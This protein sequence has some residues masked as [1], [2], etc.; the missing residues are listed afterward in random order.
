MQY[1]NLNIAQK[2]MKM[3][4]NNDFYNTFILGW[5]YLRCVIMPC[6]ADCRKRFAWETERGEVI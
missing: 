4:N 2:N 6:R 5:I 3:R 1:V